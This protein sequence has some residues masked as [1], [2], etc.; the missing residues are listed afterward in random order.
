MI[1][2]ST[3]TYVAGTILFAAAC[4]P[5]DSEP[6]AMTSDENP[7]FSESSRLLKM[8]A[9]DQFEDRHF[10]P[11][12]ERGMAEQRDEVVAIANRTDEPTLDNVFVALER[13]GQLLTRVSTVFFNLVAANTN[14]AME[15]LRGEIAGKL[16][17]HNDE[18]RLNK[19]LFDRIESVYDRRADLGLDP[20]SVRLVERYHTDFVRAGAQLAEEDKERLKTLNAELA[21]TSHPTRSGASWF[22]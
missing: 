16:A 2:R 18:I 4:T 17:A 11:A 22:R 19:A 6:G 14:D 7:L 1:S 10:A 8:P 13:S 3:L 15:A 12:F 5:S 20:E 9:F 21:E